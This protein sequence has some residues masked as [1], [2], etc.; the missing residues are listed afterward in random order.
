LAQYV[1]K[2]EELGVMQAI[3]AKAARQLGGTQSL[4]HATD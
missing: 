4:S 3:G 2:A 1:I